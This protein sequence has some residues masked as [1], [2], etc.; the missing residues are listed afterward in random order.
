[1]YTLCIA[2][3][4]FYVQKSIE[5]RIKSL[6]YDFT[7]LGCAFT[8]EEAKELYD[9]YRPDVF[10]VDIN[11]PKVDG[12][13]F[14]EMVRQEYPDNQTL[15]VIISG[16]SDYKNMRRAI[17]AEVFDYL[18][19]PIA[20][21]EFT[22]MAEHV[23]HEI[24]RM[25][26]GDEYIQEMKL[27]PVLPE[28]NRSSEPKDEDTISKIHK[29]VEEHYGEELTTRSISEMFFISASYF[30]HEFKKRYGCTFGKYLEEV[31]LTQAELMLTKTDILISE[32]AEKVG[33]EDQ[34]YFTKVFRKKYGITPTACRKNARNYT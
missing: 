17:K 7:L 4:E 1:M 6:E 10:F 25:R 2:E 22:Q 14:I 19:K 8:G 28:L 5:S 34:N 13:D 16:Y 11:L 24:E 21:D 18:E 32:I 15:F 29:Y 3:D 27:M 26:N 9:L 33:Y 31:R 12:L 30:S 23:V 20:M